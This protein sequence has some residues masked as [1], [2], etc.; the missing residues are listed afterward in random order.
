MKPVSMRSIGGAFLVLAA[1]A[2]VSTV[3]AEALAFP[4]KPIRILSPSP[5]GG[6][7][8][9]QA[10]IMADAL[11]SIFGQPVVVEAKPGASGTLAANST[12]AA[13]PDG[14]T[15]M[16]NM[17][18]LVSEVPHTV[19]TDY[20]PFT[21]LV[22]LA[23]LYHTG[24]FLVV[25]EDFPADNL[26]ELVKLVKAKPSGSY[27]FA[28]YGAGTLSHMLGLM[29]NKAANIELVHVPYKGAPLA[30][31]DLIGGHIPIAS[32]GPTP[33][34]PLVAAGRVKLL[35]YS[36]SSRS[37]LFPKVP[38]FAEAGYPDVVAPISVVL[39]ASSDM[40]KALQETWRKAV[41]TALEQEKTI[42]RMASFGNSPAPARS[43]EEIASDLKAK[44]DR[45]STLTEK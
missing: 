12:L 40:S 10:R 30:L 34:P 31:Q 4:D 28:S 15:V 35:A 19:A 42:E 5:P 13:E 32:V 6:G 24:L 25:R 11:T 41:F 27:S 9:N 1:A 43:S 39:F 7:V 14:H 22:P 8:D 37:P 21:D 18:G 36:G 26:A 3:P 33:L 45:L 16:A 44:Y 23:E 17:D 20:D 38:T 29:L 2:F